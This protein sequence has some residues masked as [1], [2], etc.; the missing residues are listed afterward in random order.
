MVA[1]KE[2]NDGLQRTSLKN[3]QMF[4]SYIVHA[5]DFLRHHIT[6][7]LLLWCTKLLFLERKKIKKIVIATLSRKPRGAG[8][9][10]I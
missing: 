7:S 1:T 5:V 2:D 4:S 8:M 3:S 10:R 6:P 9:A